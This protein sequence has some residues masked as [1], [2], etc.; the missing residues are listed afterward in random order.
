MQVLYCKLSNVSRSFLSHVEGRNDRRA[1]LQKVRHQPRKGKKDIRTISQLLLSTTRH[2]YHL[3]T[4]DSKT[5]ATRPHT[6]TNHLHHPPINTIAL[7]ERANNQKD[8]TTHN[9]ININMN[10][11]GLNTLLKWGIENSESSASA[12]PDQPRTQLDPELLAQLMGGPSDADRMIEA[13]SAIHNPQVDLENKAIAW[14]NFEQLVENLDNANNM[15]QLKLW[16]PLVDM[17]ESEEKQ[18]REM[19]CWCLGTAVQNNIKCQE[20]VGVFFPL[21]FS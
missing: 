5:K 16:M 20:R 15:E 17:L 8:K 12:A 11:A 1:F 21:F 3:A 7:H 4:D 18:N 10:D 13:M 14:D 6:S 19:A 9:N 2:F